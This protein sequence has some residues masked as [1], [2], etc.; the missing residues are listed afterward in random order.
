MTKQMDTYA[1]IGLLF[2][3]LLIIVVACM[4]VR[5][6]FMIRDQGVQISI[7]LKHEKEGFVPAQRW[8]QREA[9]SNLGTNKLMP[10]NKQYTTNNQ[11]TLSTNTRTWQPCQILPSN[12]I[13]LANSQLPDEVHPQTAHAAVKEQTMLPDV[14]PA[15]VDA[16]TVQQIKAQES[17]IAGVAE[18]AD[19]VGASVEETLASGGGALSHA[20]VEREIIPFND[21]LPAVD[22]RG[23]VENPSAQYSERQSPA[24]LNS[25]SEGFK[26]RNESS[27]ARFRAV[28]RAGHRF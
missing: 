15:K 23:I 6:Y 10:G 14:S 17:G 9:W 19:N 2:A 5:L 28:H 13:A 24:F 12:R 25:S 22:Q 21:E 18:T 11:T 20:N 26:A 4:L 7:L 27:K 1:L 3:F 16:E 8:A